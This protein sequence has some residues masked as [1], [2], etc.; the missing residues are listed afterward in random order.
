MRKDMQMGE[1]KLETIDTL[2]IG[3]GQAGLAMS[4]QLTQ[5]GHPHLVLERGRIGERWISERWR[6]LHFQTPNA[7]VA[8]PGFKLPAEDPEGFGT[9]ADIAAYLGDYAARFAVPVRTGVTVTK[10]RRTGE[11][12][13]AETS[14]GAIQ[15]KNV[16]VA[17]GPF[18]TPLIPDVLPQMPGI[19]QMHASAYLA[20]ESL[21]PGAVLVVG[22]GASG[23]QIAEELMRAGRKVYFS[24]SRHKRTPRRYRGHDHVW[25]WIKTGFDHTP[26]ALKPK[27]MLPLVHSG[28]YGGHT[29]DFRDFAAKGMVLLGRVESAEGSVVHFAGDLLDNLAEGDAGYQAVMDGIDAY[30]AKTGMD[31]PPDPA[32]RQL[33]PEPAGLRELIR[34]LDLRVAGVTTVI[35]ATGYGLDFSWI[36]IPVF[37]A[38]G[39]PRH[40]AGATEVEGL[41][42]LGLEWLSKISS[43]FLVGVGDDADRLAT[44]ITGHELPVTGHALTG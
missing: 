36:E 4:Y 7:M 44:L 10:L 43:S 42:F 31:L 9:A 15:A 1:H 40:Q 16:V 8:L 26:V 2:I 3:G 25:W 5:R 20:P 13:T 30:I 18:Q 23:A 39:R 37:D 35:W 21:P 29:I 17:T 6:G 41:F 14:A 38:S 19:V 34:E 12:F 32:A 11:G 22:A 27:E 33:A 24:V 28:A